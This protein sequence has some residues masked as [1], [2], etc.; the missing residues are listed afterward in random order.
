MRFEHLGR[1]AFFQ[2]LSAADMKLLAPYFTPQ[3]FPDGTTVFEQGDRAVFLYLVVKGEVV[4]RY[5]PEDGPRMVVT[6]VK[7]GG[8][9]GWSAAMGNPCYTSAAECEMDSEVV[10]IRG[11]DLRRL[12]N[13]YPRVGEVILDRLAAVIAERKQSQQ[14]HVTS[15]LANGI[16]QVTDGQGGN[17]DGTIQN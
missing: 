7:P 2:G 3:S 6:R 11:S 5:K 16:R 15:L 4:I 1:L 14:S 12:C 9:F 10:H 13:E 8:I 17:D